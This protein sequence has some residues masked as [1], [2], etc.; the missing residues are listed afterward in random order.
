MNYRRLST[1]CFPLCSSTSSLDR[2]DKLLTKLAVHAD[3]T[4]GIFMSPT[5]ENVLRMGS[6]P[7][8]KDEKLRSEFPD[9][10]ITLFANYLF[11]K[12]PARFRLQPPSWLPQ[13]HIGTVS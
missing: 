13:Q 3:G 1:N 7:G 11:S 5:M 9:A 10:D 12:T 2:Q 4:I 8:A 6:P